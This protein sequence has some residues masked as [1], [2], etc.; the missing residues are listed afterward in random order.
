MGLVNPWVDLIGVAP[1]IRLNCVQ[2]VTGCSMIWSRGMSTCSPCSASQ[3]PVDWLIP[4]ESRIVS[5]V[6][7]A[8]SISESKQ[9]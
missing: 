9:R 2:V 3:S 7:V 5:N 8:I 1:G 4:I 6:D